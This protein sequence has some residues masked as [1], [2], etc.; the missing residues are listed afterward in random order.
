M[1]RFLDPPLEIKRETLI[2]MSETLADLG[3]ELQACCEKAVLEGLRP[4]AGITG[5]SCVPN[6][7]LKKV[8]GGHISTRLDRG[9]RTGQGCGCK[10]SV[11][12]GSYRDQPCYHNCLFCYANPKES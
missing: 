3:I 4:G 12:I 6:D 9:Q 2:G 1:F 11:D 8:Y 10:V 7:L 5:S